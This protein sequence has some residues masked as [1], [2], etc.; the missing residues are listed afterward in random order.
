V[1][2]LM[3]AISVLFLTA[4]TRPSPPVAQAAAPTPSDAPAAA[5]EVRISG[6]IQAVRSSKVLI[7]AI[8]GSTGGSLTLTHLIPNGSSVK[9]GDLIAAFDPTQ[10]MDSARD[11][12]AKFDDLSHQVDQ[13]RAQNN[14]DA[15][16]RD[17]DLKQAEADLAKAQ[18]ELKKG[19]LLSEI[20][21]L[22]NEE[23]ASIAGAHVE[24]L[25]KSNALHDKADGAALRILE[26]QRDRQKVMLERT[27]NNINLMSIKAQIAG[28]VAHQNVFRAN[29]LGHP[30]EGDQLY[31]GQALLSIF[32]PTEMSVICSV[33]E[34]D[35]IALAPGT[36]ATVRL[37]AYPDLV[38][39]A[40][41][42]FASPV[43]SSALGSPIKNFSA[44]FR[45]E[46]SDPHLLPDLSA[47]VV[48]AVGQASRPVSPKTTTAIPEATAALHP[49]AVKPA[50]VTPAV[51]TPAGA[52]K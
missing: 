49:A 44:V 23:K 37:D 10:Q 8:Y 7:P 19:P 25:K 29:T 27:Q 21:R 30:Q 5:R 20:D 45:L 32:D 22:K 34:P 17:S 24:S 13:K 52:A 31:R 35:G 18:I 28:M 1:R 9:E 15:A 4:C 6:T 2:P 50:A 51:V 42:E 38:L 14:A 11:A 40:H 46:K 26:L 39:P 43:A 41:L 48:I 12:Q 16:K 36:H 33:G 47:A 3:A